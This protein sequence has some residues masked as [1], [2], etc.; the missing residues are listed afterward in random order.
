MHPTSTR[1]PVDHVGEDRDSGPRRLVIENLRDGYPSLSCVGLYASTAQKRRIH[2]PP[3][4]VRR[5]SL[6]SLPRRGQQE[7]CRL[8]LPGLRHVREI[9]ADMT[10]GARSVREKLFCRASETGRRPRIAPIGTRA[11]ASHSLIAIMRTS[12]EPFRSSLKCRHR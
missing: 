8:R 4:Q 2:S 9:S 3:P 5:A 1:R 11:T 12:L 7:C 6:T 10:E